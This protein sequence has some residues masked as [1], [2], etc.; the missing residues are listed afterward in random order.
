MEG[1]ERDDG[2]GGREG[3]D[4]ERKGKGEENGKREGG[5]GKRQGRRGGAF[6]Q[7][8]LYDYTPV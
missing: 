3:G 1:V 2:E 5:K 8:K 6:R 7:I 4:V